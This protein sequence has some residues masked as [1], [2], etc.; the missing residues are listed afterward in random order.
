VLSNALWRAIYRWLHGSSAHFCRRQISRPS[1]GTLRLSLSA[2]RHGEPAI[3]AIFSKTRAGLLFMLGMFPAKGV[4]R[5]V[6]I[7]LRARFAVCEACLPLIA[8]SRRHRI[9][10]AKHACRTIRTLGCRARGTRWGGG[11]CQCGA[12]SRCCTCIATEAT[13]KK[14][15]ECPSACSGGTRFQF[16]P[17]WRSRH[18][19]ALSDGLTESRMAMAAEYGLHRIPRP[20]GATQGIDA[21]GPPS[22]NALPD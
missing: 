2:R 20:G 10:C 5:N 22:R 4:L 12:S 1:A 19:V 9:F 13:R 8:W 11:V 15:L 6:M 7:H 16:T 14:P 18:T 3:T 21:A 17:T